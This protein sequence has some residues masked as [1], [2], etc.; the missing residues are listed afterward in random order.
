M[1][2]QTHVVLMICTCGVLF[3]CAN[4]NPRPSQPSPVFDSVAIVAS[5][6]AATSEVKYGAPPEDSS[7]DTGLAVGTGAGALSGILIGLAC[8]PFAPA[9]LPVTI[10]LGAATGG[11]TGGVAGA[12]DDASTKPSKGQIELL[13]DLFLDISRQ[14]II[15]EDIRRALEAK[16]PP[17]RLTDSTNA[18]ALLH[19]GR[20][21]VR[22]FRRSSGQYGLNLNTAMMVQWHLDRTDVQRVTRPYQYRSKTL[23]LDEWT[24]N[25]GESL[26]RAFDAGVQGLVTQMVQDIQFSSE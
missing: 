19:V 24:H 4:T 9:C 13:S 10:P 8:G 1:Q 21:N 14:R 5:S 18:D 17:G 23:P 20:V 2:S 6:A 22:F 3:A 26:N 7:V 25:Q 11:I 16:I 12:I 15:R